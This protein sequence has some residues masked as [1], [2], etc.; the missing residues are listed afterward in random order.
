M[1]E[2]L[3]L[4]KILDFFKVPPHEEELGRFVVVIPRQD[5]HETPRRRIQNTRSFQD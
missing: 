3:A 5:H 1:T 2:R 4:L